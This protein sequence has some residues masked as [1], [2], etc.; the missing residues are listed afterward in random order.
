MEN[1][2][3]IYITI[4]YI[5]LFYSSPLCIAN[6]FIAKCISVPFFLFLLILL[7]LIYIHKEWSDRLFISRLKLIDIN[8]VI[9]KNLK[10]KFSSS[11]SLK[12]I[13]LFSFFGILLI[14]FF[15]YYFILLHLFSFY[16]AQ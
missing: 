13:S 5:N 6:Y 15:V 8:F 1:R 7:L 16:F 3:Y 4:I 2:R 10:G 11:S 9:I 12:K 14:S